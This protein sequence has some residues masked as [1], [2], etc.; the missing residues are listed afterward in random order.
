MTP[1]PAISRDAMFAEVPDRAAADVP[2]P[3]LIDRC[4]PL[5]VVLSIGVDACTV[6]KPGY[7]P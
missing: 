3:L 4:H 7:G 5:T 2:T 6:R 1:T